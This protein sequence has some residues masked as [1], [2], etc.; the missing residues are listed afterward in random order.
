V[1]FLDQGVAEA[2]FLLPDRMKVRRGLGKY[3]LR[4]WLSHAL[5]EALPF[6]RKRGFTVPVSEWIAR[7]GDALGPLVA[8]DPGVAEICRPEAVRAMYA[9]PSRAGLAPWVLLFYALW[10]RRHVLGLDACGD[11]FETLAERI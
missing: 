3:L 1:P 9:R 7:K 10:H 2:A 6:S 8:A 5:P 4:R 11:V